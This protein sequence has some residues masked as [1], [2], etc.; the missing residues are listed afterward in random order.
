LHFTFALIAKIHRSNNVGKSL[1]YMTYTLTPEHTQLSI[2]WS[3][4]TQLIFRVT[5]CI[6]TCAICPSQWRL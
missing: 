1:L 6:A 3:A 2:H 5:L 4:L